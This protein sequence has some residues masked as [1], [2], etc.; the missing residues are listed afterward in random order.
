ML[1]T[2]K[3]AV[4][5]GSGK[6]GNY[7]VKEL[8]NRGFQV[9]ALLRRPELNS[10]NHSSL[11]VIAGDAGDYEAVSGLITGCSVVISA[12]G[13]RKDE[14][15]ISSLATSHIIRVMNELHI[16]RY[17]VITGLSLDLPG[18]K[19]SLPVLEA[20]AFMKRT[21]PLVTEDKQKMYTILSE[22]NI[23]WTIVR[24]PFIIQADD[25][26]QWTAHVEDCPGEHINTTDLAGFL[27][28]QISDRTYIR[29]APFIA[30]M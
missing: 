16:R 15:L 30:S 7:L 5:G 21:F 3:V 19:K 28:D 12:L 23:D 9:K 2:I 1:Q 11:E 4:I 29:K 22:S 26:R 13:Q 17:I 14:Q 25:R 24:L 27:I 18:D 6:A 8:L 20:S 10:L